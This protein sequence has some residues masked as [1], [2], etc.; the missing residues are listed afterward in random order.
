MGH[1][2]PKL[3]LQKGYRVVGDLEGRARI[4]VGNLR[5]LGILDRVE[6]CSMVLTDFRST[7]QTLDKVKPTRFTI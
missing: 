3:L 4:W 5:K 7:L 2:W 1:I 6:L